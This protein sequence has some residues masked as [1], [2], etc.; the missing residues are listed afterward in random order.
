MAIFWGVGAKGF[1]LVEI[2]VCCG[3]RVVFWWDFFG[4]GG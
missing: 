2:L 1:I 4:G 3:L